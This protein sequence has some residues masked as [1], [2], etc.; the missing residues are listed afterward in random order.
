M[1]ARIWAQRILVALT[2]LLVAVLSFIW[3]A[4]LEGK[5]RRETEGKVVQAF[6]AALQSG[7]DVH[8]SSFGGETWDYICAVSAGSYRR[9]LA[10]SEDVPHAESRDIWRRLIFINLQG[11]GTAAV[12]LPTDIGVYETPVCVKG[13]G[14]VLREM[15]NKETPNPGESYSR[16][17]SLTGVKAWQENKNDTD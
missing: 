4:G 1:R 17:F 13:S 15:P 12:E 6:D 3:W 11:A 9:E 16:H 10:D 8:L 2:A 14:A 7:G 5:K